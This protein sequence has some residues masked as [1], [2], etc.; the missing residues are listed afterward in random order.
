MGCMPALWFVLLALLAGGLYPR[1]TAQISGAPAATNGTM[2]V[3]GRGVVVPLFVNGR[4][5]GEV[6]VWPQGPAG[7]VHIEA[8][9]V[10]DALAYRVLP[11]AVADLRRRTDERQRLSTASIQAV[12]L[13]AAFDEQSLELRLGVP[14]ELRPPTEVAVYGRRPPPGATEALAPSDLSAFLNMRSGLEYV[15]ENESGVSEGLQ[16]F[17]LDLEG[18]VNW[19]QWVLEGDHAY[20]E[21]AD[22]FFQREGTRLVRDDPEHSIRYTFGDLM[23]PVAGFQNYQPMGGISVTRNFSLQPYRVTEPLGRASFVLKRDAKV[24]VLLNGRQVQ[25]LQMQAGPHTIRDFLFANGANDVV[26][27]ITDDTGHVETIDLSFFYDTRLLAQGEQEFGYSLGE[28]STFADGRLDYE[29]DWPAFSM[30]HRVGVTDSLTVGGNLQGDD[31]QQVLGAEAIVASLLG[32]FAVDLAGS[33][34]QGPGMGYA[35]GVQYQ[36]S[37]ARAATSAGGLLSLGA[38]YHSDGFAVLGEDGE[39]TTAGAEFYARYSQALF[40]RMSG[41][42]GGSYEVKLGDEPDI[43]SVGAFL[44]KRFGTGTTLEVTFDYST[45]AAG[46]AEYRAFISLNIQMSRQS[47]NASYDTLSGIGRSSWQYT[48]A[49]T[50]GGVATE[51]GVQGSERDYSLFGSAFYTHYLAEIG[52]SQDVFTPADG[53]AP[54]TRT[55]FNLGTALVYADGHVGVSRPITDSFAIVVPHSSLAGQEIGIEPLSG[56]YSGRNSFLSPAVLPDLQ[57]YEI[58]RVVTEAPDAPTGFDLGEDTRTL[59]PAYKSGTVIPLGTDANVTVRGTLQLADG[60]P[61][62]LQGGEVVNPRDPS[63]PPIPFFTNR[64]GRFFVE[65]LSPGE[66]ELQLLGAADAV[67]PIVIPKQQIG[68]MDLGV[69]QIPAGVVL[70]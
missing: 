51:V 9:P 42:V 53:F 67:V 62:A 44:R 13:Q 12:G 36:Y 5:Q 40:W 59:A 60:Q 33:E 7:D 22:I 61:V 66:F 39:T 23:Y 26:L 28:P 70:E 69:L 49:H 8:G 4:D 54:D 58:R 18:A 1:L 29:T 52:L 56:V 47:L 55:R 50:V 16:P 48:P 2:A 68:L 46:E 57:G 11:Q 3:Y 10:L 43:E 15:H 34:A 20:V 31:T 19:Q 6:R 24:D 27:R 21:D 65:G 38:R 14:P 41:G 37:D 25:T 63:R 17:R 64:Q 30:F 45:D 35:A 32:T